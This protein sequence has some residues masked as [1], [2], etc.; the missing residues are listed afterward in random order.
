MEYTKIN[1]ILSE[2]SL[3][4]A[5][6]A[7][8][9]LTGMLCVDSSIRCNRWLS[10]VV[11]D[12]MQGGA[13]GSQALFDL[14]EE[15]RSL[16]EAENYEFDILLPD[17]EAL[18][19]DRATALADWCRGFLYGLGNALVDSELPGESGEILRD[20]A[21]ISRLD[22]EAEDGGDEEAYMELSEYVRVGVFLLR[23]ELLHQAKKDRTH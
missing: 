2:A 4:G 19:K 21:E 18:L 22:P 3:V 16:L 20:F 9:I 1:D 10:E 13:V 14:C 23:T 17:D 6:E 7:H 15:T 5:S 12:E 8:G 11:E